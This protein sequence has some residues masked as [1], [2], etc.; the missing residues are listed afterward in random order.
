MEAV[1]SMFTT[2][3]YIGAGAVVCVVLLAAALGAAL[4]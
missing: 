2:T 1:K 4:G 3:L